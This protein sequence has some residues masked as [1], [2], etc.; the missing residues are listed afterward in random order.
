LSP[1]EVRAILATMSESETITC[2][3][4]GETPAT[5]VCQHLMGGVA[6]GFH[7]AGEPGDRWPDAWCDRCDEAFQAAGGEW[8]AE[9]EAELDIRLLCTHCYEEARDRNR[10]V[11]PHAAGA[12]ATLTEA[13]TAAL[14]HHAVH[15]LQAI[16]DASIKRWGWGAARWD[17]DPDRLT[18]TFSDPK[19]PTVI[20]DARLIGSYSTRS[21]TFQWAWATHEDGDPN[22]AVLSRLR[23]FGEVRGI[24][25]LTTANWSCEIVDGWEM[26]SLASYLLGSEG[27]YRAPFDHLYWF[28][29]LSNWRLL[30]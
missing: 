2:G 7:D 15:T 4:H 21:G 23:A 11:P 30:Q 13:E 14:I 5:F 17:F 20:A 9:S 10:S 27:V 6:C 12:S 8:T 16:Q 22:D 29:L 18:L 24:P 3:A 28:M 26:A 25:R 1:T 19:R